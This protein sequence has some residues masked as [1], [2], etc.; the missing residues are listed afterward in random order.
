VLQ[1]SRA[2]SRCYAEGLSVCGDGTLLGAAGVPFGVAE[3]EEAEV[4]FL[5]PQCVGVES[6]RQSRVRVTELGRDLANDQVA[7]AWPSWCTL[8]RVRVDE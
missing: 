6:K 5:F 7:D 4:R 3:I 2:P 8:S 1:H